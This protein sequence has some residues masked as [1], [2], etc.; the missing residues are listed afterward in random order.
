MHEMAI[1][2][3]IIESVSSEA[4]K[5][6]ATRVLGVTLWVG[7]FSCIND[8]SLSF[9]LEA[10]SPGTVLENAR[11]EIS[12]IDN[13]ACCE[14]CGEFRFEGAEMICPECGHEGQPALGTE[15][16]IGELELD[17]EENNISTES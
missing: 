8:M 15:L 5:H 7:Q 10:I 2:Q 4:C 11:I 6:N 12:Q 13:I 16:Y 14:T 9:C 17:V 1:A 3:Q